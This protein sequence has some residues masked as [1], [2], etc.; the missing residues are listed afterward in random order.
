M[1]RSKLWDAQEALFHLVDDRLKLGKD[2]QVTFGNPTELLPENVWISG[3]VDDWNTDWRVSGLAAKDESFTLRISIA[4]IRL[5]TDYQVARERVRELGREVED[6]ISADPTL[7][8]IVMLA[9]ISSF[10]LEDTLVDDRRR[11]VGLNIYVSCQAW[12]N[13]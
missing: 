1:V 8:G 12:L 5:G 9:K 6:A 3:E 13:S 7:S 10:R 4:V 2:G 11:G